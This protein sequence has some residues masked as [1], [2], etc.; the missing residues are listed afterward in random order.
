MA[1]AARKSVAPPRPLTPPTQQ[2]HVEACGVTTD[3]GKWTFRLEADVLHNTSRSLV[4]RA[5]HA[6]TKAPAHDE[7]DFVLK[8]F[9]QPTAFFAEV[10]ALSTIA[11]HPAIVEVLGQTKLCG[12]PSL[13]Y[14]YRRWDLFAA[15]EE[16][17]FLS[18][19]DT[20]GVIRQVMSALAHMHSA[21]WSHCDVKPENVLLTER[22]DAVLT[23]FEM[24]TREAALPC[25]A[26][27]GTPDWMAPEMV[28][29]RNLGKTYCPQ[30]S[31]VWA[32]GQL[33]LFCMTMHGVAV[34]QDWTKVQWRDD[35]LAAAGADATCLQFL[36]GVLAP[37]PD[38]RWTAAVALQHDWLREA[39]LPATK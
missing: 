12:L 17:R 5:T 8:V 26:R 23:D 9:K 31:D 36:G 18:A 38:A 4:A 16:L 14:Q 27:R 11:P 29:E 22:G 6:A 34:N 33:A 13:V 32:C 7:A 28:A 25:S 10:K 24:A 37:D 21:G 1:A 15:V 39:P 19:R 3:D 2:Q 30:K 35:L 20:V